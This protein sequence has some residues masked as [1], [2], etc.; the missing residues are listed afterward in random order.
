MSYVHQPITV[1]II[2]KA[3]SIIRWFMP[4][5]EKIEDLESGIVDLHSIHVDEVNINYQP[6]YTPERVYNKV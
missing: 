1:N 2:N 4:S 6:N 3:I 5:G